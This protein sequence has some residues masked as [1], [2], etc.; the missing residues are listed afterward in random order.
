MGIHQ[1]RSEKIKK[2]NVKQINPHQLEGGKCIHGGH[3]QFLMN[4]SSD[5]IVWKFSYSEF[6]D[7]V[8]LL[9]ESVV[10]ELFKFKGKMSPSPGGNHCRSTPGGGK[11][12]PWW[13]PAIPYE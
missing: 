1:E 2:S 6:N 11:I 3:Q 4:N 12:H 13:T 7:G 9:I 10:V 5:N 8:H